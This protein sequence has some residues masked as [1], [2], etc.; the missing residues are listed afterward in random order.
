MEGDDLPPNV[1][2]GEGSHVVGFWHKFHSKRE[3]ALVI[4]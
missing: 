2:I 3:P 4:G 1:E